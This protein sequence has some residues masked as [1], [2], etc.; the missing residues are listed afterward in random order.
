MP[1]KRILAIAVVSV[2]S[3]A[4]GALGLTHPHHLDGETASWWLNLHLILLPLFPL[5]GVAIWVLL[6]GH[7]GALAWAARAAALSYI[8]LYGALD[9]IA[10][11]GVGAVMVESGQASSDSVAGLDALYS[12]GNKLGLLGAGSFL[13]AAILTVAA[14]GF[15]RPRPRW[16]L[17]IPGAVVLLVAASF[18]LRSHIYWPVGVIT[19]LAIGVGFA[20]IEASRPQQRPGE[21][22]IY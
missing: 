8:V 16:S 15:A 22:P 14:F 10:G 7:T 11:V 3:L 13:A 5:L 17:F 1:R 19:V 4:L 18:F 6:R 2:P 12:I 21:L 20:L 9:A